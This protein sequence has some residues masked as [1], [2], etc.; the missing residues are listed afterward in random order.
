MFP[1]SDVI[2]S[3]TRPLVTIA[4]IAVNAAVFLYEVRLDRHEL[5]RLAH[6]WGS[7]PADF[8]WPPVLTGLFLHDGWVHFGGN[9][10]CLWIFGDNVESALG[11]AGYLVFYLAAGTFATLAHVAAHPGSAVPL[12]GASGAVAAV[13]GTYFV[14]YPRSQVLTVVFLLVSL[15]V[16]EV[17]AIFFLA[18]W[19]VLQAFS[20][21]VSRGVT[22]DGGMA[23]AAQAAGFLAGAFV[24]LAVRRRTPTWD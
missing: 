14:L 13:M 17:P 1:V 6:T 19:L 23:L 8:A 21:L 2:P 24:G 22:L 4:L 10:L 3:R 5:Y 7:V 11:H 18:M 9:M 16:V 20:A 15:D 12:V